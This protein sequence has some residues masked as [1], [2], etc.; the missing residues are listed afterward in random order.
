MRQ[1]LWYVIYHPCHDIECT[2]F[3]IIIGSLPEVEFPN[4]G[5]LLPLPSATLSD[6][7][8]DNLTMSCGVLNTVTDV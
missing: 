6:A 2:D 4:K 7:H 3:G 5:R 1:Q 8:K